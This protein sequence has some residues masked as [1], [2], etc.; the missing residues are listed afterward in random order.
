MRDYLMVG[1]VAATVGVL[2]TPLAQ[3]AAV[4]VGFVDKPNGGH[5]RHARAVPL[6]G[7]LLVLISAITGLLALFPLSLNVYEMIAGDLQ[8]VRGLVVASAILAAVGVVDDARGMRGRHKLLGQI[9]ACLVLASHG[10]EVR[11]IE[12]LGWTFDLGVMSIPFTTFWLL[13]AINAINLLDGL[14]GM[15]GTVG[16]TTAIAITGLALIAGQPLA[17]LIAVAIA[18]ALA[19]FLQGNWPP[20][21]FFLGDTGSMLIG[22]WL[23]ALTILACLK[24]PALLAIAPATALLTVPIIDAAAAVMR[25]RLTGRS[26]YMTDRGHLHHCLLYALGDHRAVLVATALACGA[27]GASAIH[28][29]YAKND[30]IAIAGSA[31]TV[32]ALICLRLFGFAE[33]QLLMGKIAVRI[34]LGSHA[35]GH[36]LNAISNCH[37]AVQ[38][39]GHRPWALLWESLIEFADEIDLTMIVLDLNLPAMKEGFHANWIRPSRAEEYERWRT[40]VPLFV[41]DMTIGRIDICGERNGFSACESMRR[42]L[43]LLTPFEHA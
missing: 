24:A 42:L 23:G 7:G 6:G 37:V 36:H 9:V 33:L 25:R 2:L 16:L 5:K 21:R 3:K 28:S 34:G 39:Q 19:A 22:C 27:T 20:A 14:D 31:L 12:L 30:V 10:F 41:N 40:S 4:R 26:M 17:A 35:S 43:E 13:G 38:L 32:L 18:G 1:I 15:A 11:Q 29:V 8:A